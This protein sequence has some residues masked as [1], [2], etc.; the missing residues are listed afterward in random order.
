MVVS[1]SDLL[2]SQIEKNKLQI[3]G[4]RNI[5]GFVKSTP[6]PAIEIKSNCVPFNIRCYWLA[7]KFLLKFLTY[8][9]HS[10]F[11]MF[12]S[13][14]LSWRYVPK[15]MPILSIAANSL[16]NFHQYIYKSTKLPLYNQSFESL[17][18]SP[19]VQFV[20]QF[21]YLSSQ[22]LKTISFRMVNSLL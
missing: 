19:I 9:Y 17:L 15:T 16:S 3:S 2:F 5:M 10:I 21:P 1:F 6:C 20:N 18:F 13:L 22:E 14:F 7:S 12:F 8:S 4:L 11:D